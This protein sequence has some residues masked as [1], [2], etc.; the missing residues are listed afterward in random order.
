VQV[1]YWLKVRVK[2]NQGILCGPERFQT[3][4]FQLAQCRRVQLISAL[5][6][7]MHDGGV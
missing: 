5:T 3:A 2:P 1:G 7:L 4:Q 6:V